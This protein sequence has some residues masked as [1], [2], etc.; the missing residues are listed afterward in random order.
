[1]RRLRGD[2]AES[3]RCGARALGVAARGARHV[4]RACTDCGSGSLRCAH[5][6]AR[7]LLAPHAVGGW[8]LLPRARRRERRSARAAR[9]PLR[10]GASRAFARAPRRASPRCTERPLSTA[11]RARA[12]DPQRAAPLR[13]RALASGVA[14]PLL[15]RRELA[16]PGRAR[17]ARALR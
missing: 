17:R 6:A 14:E 7:A 16:L 8:T 5:G 2:H 15:P 9:S 12:R 3:P 13:D 4:S 11:K 1:D 10:V